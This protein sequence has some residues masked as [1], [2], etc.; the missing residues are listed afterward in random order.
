MSLPD[1]G[2][3]TLSLSNPRDTI[4]GLSPS[5]LL[6]SLLE[7]LKP[8]ILQR[9]TH[10]PIKPTAWLDGLRGWAAFSVVCLHLGVY[11]H[12][13]IEHCYGSPMADG[14]FLNTPAA[15]PFLRIFFS[16]GHFAVMLFFT[17]SGYVICMR[18]LTLLHEGRTTEFIESLNSAIVRR[19][20]RLFLPVVW[21]TLALVFIWHVFGIATPW[22]PRQSN[23]F[24]ELVAWARET[25]KFGDFFRMGFLFTYYNIHTWTIPVELRG[26]MYLFTWLFAW[27]Q[28]ENRVR[29]IM[30]AIMV[31]YLSVGSSAGW[32]ACFFAGMLTAELDLL[33]NVASPFQIKLPWDGA[34]KWLRKRT[35][36]RWI[37]LHAMLVAGL[38]LGGQPSSD[39]PVQ[40]EVLGTC[41]GWK[42]LNYLV[43]TAYHD[44]EHGSW[45]WFWLFWAAWFTLVSVKEIPWAKALF[46]ARFSQCKSI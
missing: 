30:Q 34:F 11:T 37:L 24:W 46:E 31:L 29:I 43:P 42:T 9:R 36:L 15:W 26:S 4:K 28:A 6:T 19:P 41:Y 10:K 8:E 2:A 21:S 13:N 17:I 1:P 44:D 14:Q 12:P 35:V 32:Y 27:H 39:N 18:L 20:L 38:Y 3:P 22:P 23:L 40:A 45:R 16:G 33:A 5:K 25:G 7:A